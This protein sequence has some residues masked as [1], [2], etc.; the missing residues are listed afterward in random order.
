MSFLN[1]SNIKSNVNFLSSPLRPSVLY[2]KITCHDNFLHSFQ[3]FS[4]KMHVHAYMYLF[5]YKWDLTI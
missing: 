5:I 1:Q 4:E 2:I 3:N